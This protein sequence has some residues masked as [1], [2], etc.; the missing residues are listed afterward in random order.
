MS[1]FYGS[2]HSAKTDYSAYYA[3]LEAKRQQDVQRERAAQDA[4]DAL[5]TREERLAANRE[6]YRC[7]EYVTLGDMPLWSATAQELKLA[8]SI[9]FQPPPVQTQTYAMGGAF[10]SYGPPPAKVTATDKLRRFAPNP[11]LNAK[12][13]L[14][15]GDITSLE[16]DAVVNAANESLL[17]GGGID[18]AIHSAAGPLLLEACKPFNGCPTGET[19]FT[20]GYK[21]PALHVFHTVGPMGNGDGLLQSCYQS[22]L[23]LLLAKGLRSIALCGVGTGIFGFPLVRATHIALH[24][25]RTFLEAHSDRVDR[26]VFCVFRAEELAVYEQLL[27]S[28]FPLD[29]GFPSG[30]LCPDA[31]LL[32][33]NP[34]D[35]GMARTNT[36]MSSAS[37]GE[38]G[39]GYGGFGGMGAAAAATTGAA[40]LRWPGLD[41][42]SDGS[43]DEAWR[44][45]SSNEAGPAA[46]KAAPTDCS[47]SEADEFEAQTNDATIK[48]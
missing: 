9:G 37:D 4:I 17:G 13:S 36:N 20:P 40:G 29:A 5:P 38:F 8:E 19:R 7:D 14:Y 43:W 10:H 45:A 3:E 18:G 6:R 12:V 35:G 25:V 27:P 30:G 31:L 1:Y 15:R 21:L 33:F 44:R 42:S 2:S 16:V 32:M 41:S 24:T 34:T 46:V 22:C 23:D 47:P 39:F 26:I 11:A 48:E 28:Y